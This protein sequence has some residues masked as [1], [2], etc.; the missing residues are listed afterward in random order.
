MI[1]DGAYKLPNVERQYG[2]LLA[3]FGRRESKQVG[4]AI[5]PSGGP[6]GGSGGFGMLAI[7]MSIRGYLQPFQALYCSSLT[8]S[9]QSTT[10][11]LSAS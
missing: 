5:T 2:P 8:C 3:L 10:L 6:G 1:L 9:I 7:D 4:E 11:P